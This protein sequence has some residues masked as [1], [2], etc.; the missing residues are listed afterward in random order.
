[1]IRA[2]TS[3]KILVKFETYENLFNI[4]FIKNQDRGK[5]RFFS[6]HIQ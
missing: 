1:M 2:V 5:N 3:S 6:V 4:A